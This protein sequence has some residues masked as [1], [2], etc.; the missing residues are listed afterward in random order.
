MLL[1]PT[2]SALSFASNYELMTYLAVK[3]HDI[4]ERKIGQRNNETT[5]IQT[6]GEID[7]VCNALVAE[8]V[9]ESY[10]N[11]CDLSNNTAKL[12]GL[13]FLVL[14]TE[15]VTADGIRIAVHRIIAKIKNDAT[16]VAN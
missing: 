16:D 2:K 5:R 14:D 10:K 7:A 12:R 15:V 3:G 9:I 8:G 4:L 6:K 11:I 13:G 1:R